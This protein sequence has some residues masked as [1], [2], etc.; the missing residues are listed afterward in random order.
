MI[1]HE[2]RHRHRES[3]PRGSRLKM[4][5]E[6]HGNARHFELLGEELDRDPFGIPAHQ[7]LLFH[8]KEFGIPAFSLFSPAL[9]GDGANNLAGDFLFIKLRDRVVIDEHVRSPCLVLDFTDFPHQ[10]HVVLEKG[11]AAVKV[12]RNKCLLDEKF[13]GELGVMP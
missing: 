3:V 7:L 5:R 10:P 2:K 8:E 9:E 1:E 12:T 13:P 4:V 11:S 6:R